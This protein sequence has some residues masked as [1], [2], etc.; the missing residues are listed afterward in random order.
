MIAVLIFLGVL[1][2]TMTI[3]NFIM[4]DL[5]MTKKFILSEMVLILQYKNS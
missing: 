5:K 1:G 4:M 2:V 3:E